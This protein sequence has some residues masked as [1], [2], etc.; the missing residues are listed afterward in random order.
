MNQ[1]IV[2]CLVAAAGALLLT[3]SNGYSF[4]SIGNSVNN[5]CAPATP[6]TGD[7]SL[8][9]LSNR[10]A[11]TPAKTAALAGGST[12]TNFFCPPTTPTCT[13]NDNDGFAVEGGDCGPVDCNDS[14]AAIKPGATENCSDNIDNNCNGLVD[15]QDPAAVGCL[16]C[17]DSDVDGF[18]VEGGNCGPVDCNDNDASI[19]PTATD[20]PNNG[21]D[22][23]CSGADTVDPTTLDQDGDGYT[24]VTG[25]CNDSDAAINPG[26]FDVP[27][28]GIDENCDG[29]DSVDTSA[30]DNDGD[31]FT[32][33]AGDC[34][35][36]DGAVNPNALENCSDNI[37][38]DCNGLIDIQDPNA[39]D[40]PV[41]CT[42]LD[43]DSYSTD[44][45]SCGPVD[46]NDSD[47]TVNPGSTEICD[48]GI[49]ND[50]DGAVDEGCDVTCPDLDGDGYQD[51]ICGGDDCNDSDAAI[52]P[53]AAEVCGNA[54]DE[55]CNGASDDTCLT[56]P[57]GSLL[58]VKK[59]IY[60]REHHRRLTITGRATVGNTISVI[61]ADTGETL[62]EGVEVNSRTARWEAVLRGFSTTL[63]NITIISSN[64]CAVD[65]EISLSVYSGSNEDSDEHQSDDDHSYTRT[66]HQSDDDHS[67]TRTRE[68]SDD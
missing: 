57:D 29:A 42:D 61:N 30:L 16:V 52:N 26:A 67:Y 34:D 19:K 38:N 23:D 13:D 55:N 12:L 63:R 53:G 1:K 64:G 45:G 4:S 35:D 18:A 48:D 62:Q 11:S 7:C 24:Q 9:H 59:I 27:N 46:C 54:V 41:T 2:S 43:G 3:A 37:D 25:D 17:T 31:G 8:C 58:V 6:F 36:T 49:D 22:E 50:C 15:A 5:A 28:N 60:S 51:A 56:C 14:N 44:D 32:P 21:I 20:I 39:V 10:S 33:A 65:Q 68:R 66:R 40:C 47:A